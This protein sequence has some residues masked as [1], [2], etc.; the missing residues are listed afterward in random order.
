VEFISE[1]LIMHG[2]RPLQ[3]FVS[4]YLLMCEYLGNVDYVATYLKEKGL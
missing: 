4:S 3:G 1:K 2:T